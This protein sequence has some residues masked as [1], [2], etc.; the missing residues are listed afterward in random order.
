MNLWSKRKDADPPCFHC[1]EKVPCC[2]D[3][4]RKEEYLEWKKQKEAAYEDRKF[5]MAA[6]WY[7]YQAEERRRKKK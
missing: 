5:R 7:D 6:K 4:C 3:H 2:S 1:P